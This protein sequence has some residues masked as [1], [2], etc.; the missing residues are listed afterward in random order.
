MHRRAL[1]LAFVCACG[2]PPIAGTPG[3]ASPTPSPP[4]AAQ[5]SPTAAARAHFAIR[6]AEVIGRGVV[7]LE[8]DHGIVTAIGDV[9]PAIP[10]VDA[11]GRFIAPAFIDSHVHLAYWPVGEDLLDRGVVAVVDLAAPLAW[12]A[13]PV[14]PRELR[15]VA[16]GPMITARRGYPTRDW[17]ADGYGLEVGGPREAEAAVDELHGRGARVI[18]LPITDAPV[19]DERALRAAVARAHHHGLKVASHALSD[20]EARTAAAVGVD[21]LAHTP[22]EPLADVAAWSGRAVVSTLAAFGGAPSAVDNLRRLRAAGA[23]VL[24]GT[25]LGNTRDAGISAEEITLLQAAGLDGQAILDAGTRLP[26]AYWG[27]LDA[28]GRGPG[29]LAVGGP[30]DLLVL[31]ADPRVTPTTLA[32]PEAVYVAGVRRGPLSDP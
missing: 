24:Y 16:S 30:A 31:A 1:C 28:E 23:Q 19:L 7:D 12:L 3:P 6:G 5:A 26:A 11:R 4:S 17:G 25:D 9:D 13:A 18:K 10:G 21:A 8:I 27:L 14:A 20:A 29:A 32:A 2:S 15:V 22:V